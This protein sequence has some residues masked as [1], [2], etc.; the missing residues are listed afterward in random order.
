MLKKTWQFVKSRFLYGL[1]ALA[2]IYVTI[3]VVVFV[4]HY[5][6]QSMAPVL[7]NYLPVHIP[8]LG[9][10]TALVV[11][12]LAGF[13]A[14]LVV[15]RQATRYFEGLI[16]SIPLVRTVYSGVKQVVAPL[17]GGDSHN[18]FKQV[19]MIEWPGNDLW[20]MG[21]LVKDDHAEPGPDDEVIIFLPTNHLH[22]GF[23]VATRRDRLRPVEI[24]IEEALKMQFSLGVATPGIPLLSARQLAR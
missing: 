10:I 16:T 5:A 6:D 2:P 4:V 1:V 14:R 11:I 17:L 9:L 22:L 3:R 7:A 12:L 15:F 19:V 24:S 23:V 21:F 8:G 13:L 20:V 18:A